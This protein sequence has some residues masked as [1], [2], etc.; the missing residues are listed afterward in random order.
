MFETL[1]VLTIATL[2]GVALLGFS[3]ACS[4]ERLLFWE[5]TSRLCL[6]LAILFVLARIAGSLVA[7]G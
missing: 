4:R 5:G 2:L 1:W 6:V 7:G 3:R